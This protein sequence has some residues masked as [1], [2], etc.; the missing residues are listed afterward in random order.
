MP[1]ALAFLTMMD[2]PA[3]WPKDVLYILQYQYHPSVP[4]HIRSHIQPHVNK[5]LRSSQRLVVIR[6][7]TSETHPAHGQHG[8]FAAKKIPPR[9]LLLDYI[10]QVHCDDR[11]SDYDLS[12]YRSQDGLSVGIDATTMGNE[13]R[14]INDYRGIADK[15][16]ALF[17]DRRT[18]EGLL[19]MGVWS[20]KDGMRKGEEVT[21]SYGKCWWRG[22]SQGQAGH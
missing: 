13:A 14:F 9:T 21:V 1:R 22:R 19:C 6:A 15:P 11:E 2:A 16:N 18:E 4:H 5:P 12:L 3:R 20:G 10:G 7:I 8:L 17:V